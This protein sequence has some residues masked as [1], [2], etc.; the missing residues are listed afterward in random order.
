M[1]LSPELVT[2]RDVVPDIG[3][4]W[5]A[6]EL[7]AVESKVRFYS[8]FKRGDTVNPFKAG[9]SECQNSAAEMLRGSDN[10]D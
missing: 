9:F 8:F 5:P 2:K 6:S 3:H 1:Q 10:K 7:S 4:P